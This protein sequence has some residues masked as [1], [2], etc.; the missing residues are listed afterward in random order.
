[1]ELGKRAGWRL[2]SFSGEESPGSSGHG[3]GES[4]GGK[5]RRKVPQ[6]HTAWERSAISKWRACNRSAPR[7]FIPQPDCWKLCA[8]PAR[9]KWCG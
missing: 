9:V 6:K 1:M 4:P 7:R 5:T 8:L 3:A 2:Q